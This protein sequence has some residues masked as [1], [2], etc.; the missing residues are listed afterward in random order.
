MTIQEIIKK[1]HPQV[2]VRN[3]ET[4]IQIFRKP[5][6]KDVSYIKGHKQEIIDELERQEAEREAKWAA[7]KAE[8]EAAEKPLIDA[9]NEEADRLRTQLPEGH[10]FVE[11]KEIGCAD[12]IIEYYVDG[13]KVNR[14]DVNVIGWATATRPGAMAPF[15]SVCIAS[16][17]LEKLEEIKAKIENTEMERQAEKEKA[18]VERQAKFDEAKEAGKPV[19]LNRYMDDCNNPREE[20]STDIVTVWAMPDGTTKTTR[21]HTW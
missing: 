5:T 9:M 4:A 16:I 17:S 7:Q 1:Y 20:C 8:Q 10:T 11:V 15:K 18:K 12:P 19:E 14:N 2:T 6:A 21:Q 13:K 3:G